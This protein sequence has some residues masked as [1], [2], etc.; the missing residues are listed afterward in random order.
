MT[1]FQRYFLL[2]IGS[3]WIPYFPAGTKWAFIEAFVKGTAYA[4]VVLNY[5]YCGIAGNV[6]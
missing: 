3:F 1:K 4:E 5:T 2:R 6:M